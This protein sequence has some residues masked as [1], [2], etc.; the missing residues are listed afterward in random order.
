MNSRQDVLEELRISRKAVSAGEE[1]R[2][3]F[4]VFSP[5]GNSIGML[6]S[7]DDEQRQA[8]YRIVRLFMVWKAA[9]GFILA[10]KTKIPDAITC[11]LVTRDEVTVALQHISRDPV[12]FEKPQWYGRGEVGDDIVNLL[13]ARIVRLNLD[14][15]KIIRDFE[16]SE[17]GL[18]K[19]EDLQ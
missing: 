16:D 18:F 3:R 1:L 15:L 11:T 9:T 6:P 5:T 13:P 7:A 12:I 10:S 17:A 4:L 2:P 14:E 8:Q 19:L